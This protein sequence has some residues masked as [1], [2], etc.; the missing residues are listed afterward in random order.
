LRE[1]ESRL[2]GLLAEAAAAGNYDAA[3]QLTEWARGVAGLA[4]VRAAASTASGDFSATGYRQVD[5]PGDASQNA[6]APRTRSTRRR[7][8]SSVHRTQRKQKASATAYPRFARFENKLVKTGWSKKAKKEYEHKAPRRVL[9][10]LLDRLMKVRAPG[11]IFTTEELFPL[12]DN[13]D[14][15]EIPSYQAYL[16]LAWLRNG[17]LVEQVGRQGYRLAESKGI[18]REAVEQQWQ[19]LPSSVSGQPQARDLLVQSLKDA[20]NEG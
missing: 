10:R 5:G 18:L 8:K 11:E 7:K 15:S 17:N 9:D 19:A 1:C 16:C 13:D 14:D 20:N 6:R 12:R 4:T 3:L 2:R